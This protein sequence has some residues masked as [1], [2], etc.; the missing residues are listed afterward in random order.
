MIIL[1]FKRSICPKKNTELMKRDTL[2]FHGSAIAMDG[3]G[4]G[5]VRRRSYTKEVA[6]QLV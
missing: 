3:E 2:L 5:I 6:M 1:R 4:D